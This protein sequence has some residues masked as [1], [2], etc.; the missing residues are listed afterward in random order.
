MVGIY[1]PKS[2]AGGWHAGSDSLAELL[3]RQMDASGVIP[4]LAVGVGGASRLRP[5]Y[6]DFSLEVIDADSEE[7]VCDLILICHEQKFGLP[8]DAPYGVVDCFI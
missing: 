4:Q 2:G 8:K 1:S 7:E 3:L 5:N 6:A